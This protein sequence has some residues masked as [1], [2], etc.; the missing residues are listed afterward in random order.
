MGL[1]GDVQRYAAFR[2]DDCLQEVTHEF[3]D[4]A[5][6]GT[7]CDPPLVRRI[8]TDGEEC[9]CFDGARLA[10]A[11]KE[12]VEG[13]LWDSHQTMFSSPAAEISLDFDLRT[14]GA[15][16]L[17]HAFRNT[18]HRQRRLGVALYVALP[19]RVRHIRLLLP[20]DTI[21]RALVRAVVATCLSPKMR[22]R[23][24]HA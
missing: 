20:T 11:S 2:K 19:S 12:E 6:Q 24:C 8:H 4:V 14:T 7:R 15:G 5:E 1:L 22:A 3:G 23:V 21:S 10:C 18:T 17:V 16:A 13:L 9:L